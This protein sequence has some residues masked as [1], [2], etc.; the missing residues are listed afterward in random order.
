MDLDKDINLADTELVGGMRPSII[1][2]LREII[3]L[4]RHLSPEEPVSGIDI[5]L[6]DL[7]DSES[8]QEKKH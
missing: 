1:D 5:V 8:L 6:K 4:D 3:S 2:V 7:L